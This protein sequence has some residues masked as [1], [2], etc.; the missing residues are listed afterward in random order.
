MHKRVDS[1]VE[2]LFFHRQYLATRALGDFARDCAFI[3][4]RDNLLDQAVDQ[5]MTHTAADSLAVYEATPAGYVRVRQQGAI[6]FPGHVEMDDT[7]FVRL[8]S[9][10]SELALHEIRSGLGPEGYV[11]PMTVRGTLLGAFVLGPR[12]DERYAPDER[13]LLF[14]VVHEV[15]AALLALRARDNELLVDRLASGL[16]SPH[17]ARDQARQLVAAGQTV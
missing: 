7:A 9:Q 8:R 13:E 14:R 10:S 16:L 12:L 1:V 2:R 5:V 3:T 4:R 17:R 11:F 6:V 15:G